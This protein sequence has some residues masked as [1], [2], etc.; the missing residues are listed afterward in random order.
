MMALGLPVVLWTGYVQHV[1]RRALTMTP[2]FTPGGT[3]SMAQGTIATM[4]LKAAPHVS[5]YRTAR[6]GLYALGA[7]IVMVAAFMGM[8]AWGIGP[9]GSLLASGALNARDRVM[10]TDFTVSGGDSTLGRVV[11]DAVRAGLSESSVFTLVSQGE[12]AAALERM[13]QPVSTRI[14]LATARQIA[15]REGFKAIIDGDE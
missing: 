6:G 12:V 14:D 11:S 15:Q 8:R 5:W 3:P 2:T 7:F 10:I 13:R 1:T 9:F 4:A